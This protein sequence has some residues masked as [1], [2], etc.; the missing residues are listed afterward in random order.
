MSPEIG[1]INMECH[2]NFYDIHYEKTNNLQSRQ[3]AKTSRD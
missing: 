1:R 2:N 3:D